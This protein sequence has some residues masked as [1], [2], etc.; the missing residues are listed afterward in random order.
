DLQHWE[1]ELSK[2]SHRDYTEASLVEPAG[3]D[4]IFNERENNSEQEWQS[5]GSVLEASPKAGL[6]IEVRNAFN[7]GDELELVPFKGPAVRIVANEIVD[8]SMRPVQ[9]TKPSTLVRLPYVEGIEA[10]NLVRGRGKS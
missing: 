6:V 3:A 8:L 2:V 7:Q 5:I 4:S 9:R 10:L 1:A